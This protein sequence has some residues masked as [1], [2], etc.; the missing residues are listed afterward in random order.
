[1]APMIAAMQTIIVGVD[2]SDTARRAA[3]AAAKLASS[4]GKSLHVVMAVS[5]RKAVDVAVGGSDRWHLDSLTN[6]EQFL[7]ALISELPAAS[8]TRAVSLQDPATA[9]CE[10]AERLEAEMI[11]VGNR[12]VQG[13]ARL[14]GAVATDVARRAPCDVLITNTTSAR[15][16]S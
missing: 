8:V 5:N 14:L 10:E 6:A 11:V 15:L 1:M 4:C 9:L 12:R 16:K 2:Q 13:A 7:D 3:F